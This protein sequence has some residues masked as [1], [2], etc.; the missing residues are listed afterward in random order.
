MSSSAMRVYLALFFLN[1]SLL[2][3][4]EQ[5][6]ITGS[7]HQDYIGKSAYLYLTADAISGLKVLADSTTVTPDGMFRFKADLQKVMEATVSIDRVNGS[8]F[9]NPGSTYEMYFPQLSSS[10]ARTFNN[11]NVVDIIFNR[12][13]D[14]DINR[15]V[16]LFNRDYDNFFDLNVADFFDKGFDLKLDEFRTKCET[17][18]HP[19]K[20]AF[21]DE[22]MNYAFANF[23]LSLPTTRKRIAEKYLTKQTVDINNPEFTTF[24]STFYGDYIERFEVFAKNRP[25]TNAILKGSATEF[26]EQLKHDD[27]IKN[28]PELREVV[29]LL[30]LNQEYLK[31][32]A[33]KANL[34]KMMGDISRQASGTQSK[35]LALNLIK[36][37]TRLAKGSP[38]YPFS[39]ENEGGH[40]I[41][42]AGL[43]NKPALLVFA[44]SW[45]S[46]SLKELNILNDL[47]AKYGR[48]INFVLIDLD[49][50]EDG[51]AEL[52]RLSGS[53]LTQ[54]ANFSTDKYMLEAMDVFYVPQFIII[55]EKG[56][57]WNA[58]A[59]MPSRGLEAELD[60]VLR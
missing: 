34:L 53:K 25:L 52:A 41:S 29:T 18:Y 35:Q 38:V 21:L 7:A 12:L 47:Y 44:A 40:Q 54:R 19:Y 6:V 33:Q 10:Q 49:T 36:V 32:G 16:G 46:V 45:S 57:Y 27:G 58:N 48:D 20:N 8:V 1:F 22:Y 59:P 17:T 60:A 9:L 37:H 5:V 24:I 50:M 11:T 55:D 3:S 23:E 30:N 56:N 13:P 15:L 26:L 51:L 28:L 4:A 43:K 2:L 42:L 39:V 31:K 14:T